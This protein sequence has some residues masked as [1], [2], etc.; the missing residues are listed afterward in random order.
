MKFSKDSL[1]RRR[2][3][4]STIPIPVDGREEFNRRMSVI[5]QEL[6]EATGMEFRWH[7][8]IDSVNCF[9]DIGCLISQDAGYETLRT[10]SIPT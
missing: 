8:T 2:W 5:A 1:G 10:L 7:N 3:A 6:S 9:G 4:H